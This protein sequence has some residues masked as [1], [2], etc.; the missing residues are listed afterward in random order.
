MSTSEV[1]WTCQSK[2]Y[3]SIFGKTKLSKQLFWQYILH[4]LRLFNPLKDWY[5]NAN[6]S[7]TVY[8]DDVRLI[9]I[10]L[11]IIA[12]IL[13]ILIPIKTEYS[14]KT[15]WLIEW[16]SFPESNTWLHPF[17]LTSSSGTRG[18]AFNEK[19]YLIVMTWRVIMFQIYGYHGVHFLSSRHILKNAVEHNFV[20]SG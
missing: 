12:C 16:Q 20:H 19:D 6:A 8:T 18:R 4:T 15:I 1:Y 14:N 10:K 11:F 17:Y 7:Y 2:W 9:N 5:R 13:R 3:T